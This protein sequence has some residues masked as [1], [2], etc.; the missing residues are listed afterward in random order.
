[1]TASTR[2]TVPAL[3]KFSFASI[4]TLCAPWVENDGIDPSL[5]KPPR[6]TANRRNYLT[7]LTVFSSG[8]E[9][10]IGHLAFGNVNAGAIDEAWSLR[11]GARTRSATSPS[12]TSTPVRS[13]RR[14]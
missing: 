8:S 14:G 2:T 7:Q 10:E 5:N 4:L 9:D 1:M 6:G 3:N 11:Q 13:T 12:A